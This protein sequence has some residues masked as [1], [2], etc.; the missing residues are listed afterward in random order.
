MNHG[1]TATTRALRVFGYTYVSVGI[2]SGRGRLLELKAG[3][4]AR[5]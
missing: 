3:P 5:F 1:R 4:N 2:W